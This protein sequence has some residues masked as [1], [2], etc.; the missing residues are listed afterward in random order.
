M[1]RR[2]HVRTQ[3]VVI[4]TTFHVPLRYMWAYNVKQLASQL[5]MVRRPTSYVGIRS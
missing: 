5:S 3:L 1:L 2:H 4:F